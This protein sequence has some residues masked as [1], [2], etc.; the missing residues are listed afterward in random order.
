MGPGGFHSLYSRGP[1][2]WSTHTPD[3]LTGSEG[4]E[5]NP[6]PSPQLALPWGSRLRYQHRGAQVLQNL[7]LP[8]LPLPPSHTPEHFLFHLPPS[9]HLPSL[10]ESWI[11]LA[12]S[13]CAPPFTPAPPGSWRS[14]KTHSRPCGNS[15][16][17]PKKG[18]WCVL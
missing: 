1:S 3:S 12:S 18:T 11:P 5:P 10:L 7:R 9:I 4:S 8:C 16:L 15:L 6:P 2:A 14:F 17:L 13:Y